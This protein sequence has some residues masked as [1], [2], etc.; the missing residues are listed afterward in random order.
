MGFFTYLKL[1]ARL[2]SDLCTIHCCFLLFLSGTSSS[3]WIHDKKFC[4]ICILANALNPCTPR[5]TA[6][7]TY[8]KLYPQKMRIVSGL[9]PLKDRLKSL[10][11][12]FNDLFYRQKISIPLKKSDT[13][14]SQFCKELSADN[15]TDCIE[16]CDSASRGGMSECGNSLN[17]W[18]TSEDWVPQNLDC[19]QNS[20]QTIPL[21]II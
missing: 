10:N 3:L 11:W 14:P 17:T 21:K 12:L 13:F 18:I 15:Y 9:W 19:S 8:P 6:G 20:G 16:I 1:E 4:G 5:L 2:L 7:W